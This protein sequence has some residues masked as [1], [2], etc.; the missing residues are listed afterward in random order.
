MS[1]KLHL[2]CGDVYLD[3]WVNVDMG[4][5]RVDVVHNL[6]QLPYPFDDNTFSVIIGNHVIE[7][8]DQRKWPDIVAELYRISRPN[9]IWEFRCPYALSDNYATD[10]THKNPLSARSFNYFDPTKP[11]HGRL[12]QIYGFQANLRVLIGTQ[13]DVGKYGPDLHFRLLV[14]K[15]DLAPIQVPEGFINPLYGEFNPLKDKLRR[16]F[17]SIPGMLELRGKK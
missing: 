4:D 1:D 13:L 6:D 2:G 3:G 11:P 16:I 12:G 5:C 14:V 15:E 9:A 17:Y 8:L 10:P 7:H